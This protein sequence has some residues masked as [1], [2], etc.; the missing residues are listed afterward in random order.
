M[1]TLQEI[2]NHLNIVI[3]NVLCRG[4]KKPN[5]NR[6]YRY[7]DYL[8]VELTKGKW[9]IVSNSYAVK[10]LLRLRVW[11]FHSMGYACA[12]VDNTIKLFHQVYLNYDDGLIADHIN[13]CKFDNRFENLRTVTHRQNMRNRT[14]MSNNTSGM[15]G[16]SENTI[17]GY[18]YCICQIRNNHNKTLSKY[19]RTDKLGRAEALRQ[20]VAQR[21][22]WV[23]EFGYDHE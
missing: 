18:P 22:L 19:Y 11:S 5:K 3:D 4:W 1:T 15:T 6:Y 13:R 21:Q 7:N 9:M 12:C 8:I 17:N 10:R 2:Q 16:V 20:A 14:K 23:Q